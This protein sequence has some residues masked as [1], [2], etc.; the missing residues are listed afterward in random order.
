MNTVKENSGCIDWDY[1][2]SDKVLVIKVG[3]LRK[4]ESQY[5]SEPW[6]ITLVHTNALQ[7]NC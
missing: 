3:I 6:T 7:T 2:P 1:Q 4:S 5:E